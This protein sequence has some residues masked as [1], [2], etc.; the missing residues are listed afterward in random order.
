MT[1][2][3]IRFLLKRPKFDLPTA[4]DDTVSHL[5]VSKRSQ[6]VFWSVEKSVY[7]CA[8]AFIFSGIPNLYYLVSSQ[9]DEV[10]S[11]FIY[12]KSTHRCVMT[13]QVS[14]SAKCKW[15]PKNDVPFLTTAR[16]KSVFWRVNK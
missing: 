6:D 14:E 1:C 4:Q 13:V 5:I 2:F 3:Y 11:I 10:E 7:V 8:D 9:A 15:L 16:H 12:V